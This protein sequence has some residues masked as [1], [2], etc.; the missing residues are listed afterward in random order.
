M[1]KII[2][3]VIIPAY[4]EE[5]DLGF[6]LN[7]LK[8]QTFKDFEVIVIDDGSTDKTR[9]I[10]KLFKEVRLIN[11]EHKGPGVSRNLGARNAKGEILIFV[12]A[13]M[14]FDKNYIKNL[15][16]PILEG[17]TFGTIHS[18]EYATNMKNIWSKCWGRVRV[19]SITKEQTVFRAIERDKF[20]KLGGFNPRY[21]YADDQTFWYD[22]KLKPTI[23]ENTICYHRNPETLKEV[24]KQSR[25]IGASMQNPLI[26]I[27]V[28]SQLIPFLLTMASPII[29]PILALRKSVTSK[30]IGLFF[31]HM[32][33]FMAFRYFG[34]ISG[35][36]RKIYLNKN[37]K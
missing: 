14:T 16:K 5:K 36:F 30:E 1:K 11:G 35:L 28:I 33:I 3:S 18:L 20:L 31:P 7:S 2:A 29:I 15:I 25:W 13:D 32:I 9:D 8:G 19:D 24:Y 21:G 34:T 4:N 12:D 23:A 27:P 37:F 6:A 17:K 26:D 22:H 10:V